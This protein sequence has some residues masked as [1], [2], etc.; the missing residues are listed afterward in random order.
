LQKDTWKSISQKKLIASINQQ[1]M[2]ITLKNGSVYQIV[3]SDNPDA[4]RGA[5]IK[6]VV[7]SEYAEQS[8]VAW[9]TI[10]PM[11]LATNGWAMFNFTPKGQ[12]HAYDLYEMAR[13]D[14][15]WF[16]QILTV[17]DTMGQVFTQEQLEQAK[18]EDLAMGKNA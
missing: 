16:T 13:K 18:S 11:L 1:E 6:G 12:N 10:K 15:T 17:D 2:R 3:G 7:F 4:L 8:P 14:K 5:G 9:D